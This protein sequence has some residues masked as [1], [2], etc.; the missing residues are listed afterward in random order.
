[1]SLQLV[2]GR[3][4][5]QGKTRDKEK[6]T[7]DYEEATAKVEMDEGDMAEI[8]LEEGDLALLRTESGGIRVPVKPSRGDSEGVVFVPMGPW[9]NALIPDETDG[10]GMPR[11]KGVPVEVERT[12]GPRTD[13]DGLLG[14]DV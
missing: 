6:L 10:T 12:E 11:F 8:G 2:S 9:A 13:L 7:E 5:G 3:T 1:M 4:M 14:E